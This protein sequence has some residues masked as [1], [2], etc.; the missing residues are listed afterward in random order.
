MN[1]YY[2]NTHLRCGVGAMHEQLTVGDNS[3]FAYKFLLPSD[4]FLAA[5]EGQKAQLQF[6]RNIGRLCRKI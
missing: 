4:A 5:S 6:N 2:R 3:R 1:D